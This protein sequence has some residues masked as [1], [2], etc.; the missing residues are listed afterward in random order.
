MLF[1]ATTAGLAQLA[2]LVNSQLTISPLLNVE[3][4]KVVPVAVFNPFTF[5]W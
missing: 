1:D 5:H 2:L 4:M 3:V